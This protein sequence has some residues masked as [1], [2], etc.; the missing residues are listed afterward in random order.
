MVSDCN[1]FVLL[2][3]DNRNDAMLAVMAMEESGFN[4]NFV[5]VADGVEATDFLFKE[6][7]KSKLPDIILLDLNMPRVDGR[8]LLSR[9]R[10]DRRFDKTAVYI[11]STSDN[12]KDVENA[13]KEKADCYIVKPMNVDDFFEAVKKACF[14]WCNVVRRI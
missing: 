4:A 6:K 12:I 14:F 2:V 10:K 7:E 11:L 9:I 1:P 5:H 13:Y 8:Q 3:E